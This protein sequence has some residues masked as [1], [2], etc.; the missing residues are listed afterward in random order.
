MESFDYGKLSM[1]D[2]GRLMKAMLNCD[3]V[4]LQTVDNNGEPI[5]VQGYITELETDPLNETFRMK[6]E[7]IAKNTPY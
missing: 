7:P 3:I 2:Y 6:L 5:D 1:H 4:R